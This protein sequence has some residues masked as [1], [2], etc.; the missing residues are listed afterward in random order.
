MI[1]PIDQLQHGE[2]GGGNTEPDYC[3]NCA[4]ITDFG[5]CQWPACV[6]PRAPGLDKSKPEATA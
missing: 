6:R 3:A 2:A 1:Y 4:G 5:P